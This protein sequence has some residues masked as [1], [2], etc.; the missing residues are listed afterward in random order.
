MY[1]AILCAIYLLTQGK[2]L[3]NRK[4]R[5]KILIS[6][7]FIVMI[8]SFFWIPLIEHKQATNYE[9]FKPGRMERTE[10]LIAFKLNLFELFITPSNHI[11]VYE[12][13]VVSIILLFTSPIVIKKMKRKLAHTDFYYFYLF[14]FISGIVCAFMTL[15]IVPFEHLPSLL[16]MI[17]FSYRL[18][19]FSS[20]FFAFVVAVNATMLIKKIK[21]KDITMILIVLIMTTIPLT[22]HLL[23]TKELD[24]ERFIKTVPVTA[25]TGRVHAGCAS[26]EYLPCKAFENRNYL[27][28][29][30]DEVKVLEGEAQIE[31]TKKEDAKLTCKLHQ[32]AE[33]TKVE[34]PYIYYLGYEIVLKKEDKTIKL[35]TYE[36]ENGFL[37][38]TLPQMEEGVLELHYEGTILMKLSLGISMLGAILGILLLG[39]SNRKKK[40][41]SNK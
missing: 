22:S 26:F 10:V 31:E 28:T 36:T 14:A 17:Q 33:N 38:T 16:K 41:V 32:V 20:F 25:S 6:I 27:E 15:K 35:E 1:T 37:G 21:Y 5:N 13:G 40:I 29:R 8:T 24:E 7:V 18:L 23:Y 9:V 12:I 19:E 30:S 4:I 11:W 39:Y 3:K 2:K 34:L